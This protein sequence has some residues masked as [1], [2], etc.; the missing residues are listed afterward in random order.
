M[1]ECFYMPKKI[2]FTSDVK[3][4]HKQFRKDNTE[5]PE[6]KEGGW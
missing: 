5:N 3:A 4:G 6:N 1:G 2:D